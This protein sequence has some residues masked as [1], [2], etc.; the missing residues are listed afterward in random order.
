MNRT[1]ARTLPYSLLV[2]VG[3]FLLPVSATHA[4]ES[5][6]SELVK[7]ASMNRDLQRLDCY[8]RLSGK[9]SSYAQEA[10]PASAVKASVATAPATEQSN[11]GLN[12]VQK[13]PTPASNPQFG[14]KDTV[15]AETDENELH[16]SIAGEFKG[17]KK[18]DKLV[19]TNGQVWKV[20]DSRAR[21]YFKATNPKVTIKRTMMSGFR[22]SLD[23]SN[24]STLV[25]RVK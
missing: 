18:N 1:I 16:T 8:D 20:I 22:I 2:L 10:V 14:F 23:G 9:A 3:L 25:K 13:A 4:A 19:M 6:N 12:D 21:L 17:W 5:L 15:E 11:F 7:C 24:Q